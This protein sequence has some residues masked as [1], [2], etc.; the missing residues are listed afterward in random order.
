MHALESSR[1]TLFERTAPL[2]QA[3]ESDRGIVLDYWSHRRDPMP[4]VAARFLGESISPEDRVLASA[5]V[6]L[7]FDN[8]EAQFALSHREALSGA[9]RHRLETVLPLLKPHVPPSGARKQPA[10][11]A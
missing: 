5:L 6:D 4:A 8:M 2:A 7:I 10:E 1:A 9:F 3:I 11:A